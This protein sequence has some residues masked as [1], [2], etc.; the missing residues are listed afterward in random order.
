MRRNQTRSFGAE[1]PIHSIQ[2]TKAAELR[3]N[4]WNPRA[5]GGTAPVGS[6]AL[7]FDDVPVPFDQHVAAFGAI[8]VLPVSYTTRQISCIYDSQPGSR[9]DLTCGEQRRFRLFV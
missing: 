2:K 6:D 9:A 3:P 8:R 4:A 7:L 1:L 5:A